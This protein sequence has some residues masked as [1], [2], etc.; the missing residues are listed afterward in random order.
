MWWHQGDPYDSSDEEW[1]R[2]MVRCTL[3]PPVFDA[4]SLDADVDMVNLVATGFAHDGHEGNGHVDAASAEVGSGDDAAAEA[5]EDGVVGEDSNECGLYEYDDDVDDEPVHT[6]ESSVSEH[7]VEFEDDDVG[8]MTSDTEVEEEELPGMR[9]AGIHE[10]ILQNEAACTPPVRR[11]Q[12][13]QVSS[14]YIV[15][16]HMSSA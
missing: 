3:H 5:V 15:N 8:A 13:I 16:E 11:G 9:P 10:D 14:H 1:D 12:V 2:E 6:Y 7:S 4:H